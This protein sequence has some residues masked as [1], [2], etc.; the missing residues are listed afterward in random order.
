M[1]LAYVADGRYDGFWELGLNPWDVA[2]GALLVQ[3]AGGTVTD[4]SG[5]P[6]YHDGASIA[7]TN[8]PLHGILLENL[9]F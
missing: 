8:G 9:T 3:E 1:D 4:C 2:A 6:S 7:T 5:G